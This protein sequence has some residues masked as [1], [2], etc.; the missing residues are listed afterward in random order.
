L[1]PGFGLPARILE[2]RIGFMVKAAK[3]MDVRSI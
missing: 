2:I 1:R 3:D